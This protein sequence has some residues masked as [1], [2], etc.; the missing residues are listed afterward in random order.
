MDNSIVSS[1]VNINGIRTHYVV[2]GN[3]EP[4]VLIHGFGPG[5]SGYYGWNR[6]INALAEHYQV[7]ALDCLGFGETL[8]LGEDYSFPAIFRHLVGFMDALC[9]QD[10]RLVGNSRGAYLAARYTA[11]FPSRVKKLLL[12]SSGSIAEAMGVHRPKTPEMERAQ[13]ALREYDGTKAG[14]RRWLETIMHNKGNINDELLDARVKLAALP[15][16][17]EARAAMRADR[18]LAEE[19]SYQQ[20]FDLRHRLPR[21]T[22]PIT[23]VWGKQDAFAPVSMA[24]E[25]RAQLPNVRIEVFEESG[26]QC[27]NDEVERFNRL[28]RDFFAA[29]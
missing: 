8:K 4:V 19:P 9:L 24:E 22:L 25:L 29:D 18:K 1:Y 6:T 13:K 10:I 17:E 11:E 7:Y 23:L 28:A 27:Q 3:G 12:V 21:L 5:G 20:W 15:G 14:M 16:A 26:H 2:K